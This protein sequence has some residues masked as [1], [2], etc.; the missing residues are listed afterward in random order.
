MIEDNDIFKQDDH[1]NQQTGDTSARSET[2]DNA[3]TS[4][5]SLIPP[6]QIRC[7]TYG[8]IGVY[9][10]SLQGRSHKKKNTPCQDSNNFCYLENEKILIAAIADGVGSCIW[11]HWGSYMA[12]EAAILSLKREIAAISKGEVLRIESLTTNQIESIFN[13]AFSDARQAVEDLADREQQS[14]YNFQSTLTVALYDGS[15][16]TCCHIGD[17]GIVAQGTSGKYQMITQRIK[18]DEANSVVTLQSGKWF[19]TTTSTEVTGF[20]MST[21]GILDSYVMNQA[22]NNR[23]FYPFFEACVYSMG[24]K[25]IPDAL[26]SV[27]A[28]MMDTKKNLLDD[29]GLMCSVT[30]DMTVLAVANQRLLCQSIRPTFSREEWDRERQRVLKMQQEKLHPKKVTPEPISQ[31]KPVQRAR[32]IPKET[33]TNP[34]FQQKQTTRIRHGQQEVVPDPKP[35]RDSGIRNNRKSAGKDAHGTKADPVHTSSNPY[36]LPYAPDSP[37]QITLD[38][39]NIEKAKG[40][41]ESTRGFMAK[42]VDGLGKGMFGGMVIE[43]EESPFVFY[44]RDDEFYRNEPQKRNSIIYCPACRKRLDGKEKFC[45]SCGIQLRR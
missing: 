32:S 45:P 43:V 31:N 15:R 1:Q 34:T 41:G 10:M 11:S 25:Q 18:G 35:N 40:F 19:I 26:G 6:E 7:G 16:L 3:T 5:L 22:M 8:E 30:D 27:E 23:V 44:S 14:V 21:D 24:P 28:A 38:A 4:V 2:T 37:Y 36:Y 39:E 33:S 29:E 20:L 12:V 13:T 17:D 9:G 42:V